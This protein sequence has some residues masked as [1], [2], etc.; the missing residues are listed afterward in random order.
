MFGPLFEVEM[1]KKCTCVRR[2]GAKHGSKS[3]CAKH[4]VQTTFGHVA[5]ANAVVARSAFPSQNAQNYMLGPLVEVELLKKCT[6]LWREARVQVK[7]V[8]N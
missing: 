5:K 4:H 7:S 2:C 6:L 3:K 8:K 1:S